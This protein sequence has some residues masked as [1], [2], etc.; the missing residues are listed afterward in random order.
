MK[1]KIENIMSTRLITI[2]NTEGLEAAYV[3]MKLNG[4]RHLP[5]I[6]SKNHVVGII[7]DRDI[8]RAMMSLDA[9]D[10][11]FNPDDTV[12]DYMNSQI[13][14]VAQDFEL[15]SVVQKMIDHQISA[16]LITQGA[17]VVG[18]VTH[19]DLLLILADMLKPKDNVVSQV[20]NWIYKTPV[21]EIAEKLASVGI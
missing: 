2:Q 5:V 20:Q 21:G 17:N 7:S 16:V 15:L 19:E 4:I 8:Q 13:K 1:L 18:I 9:G 10:F 11:A 14:S 3:K 6:D 12:E